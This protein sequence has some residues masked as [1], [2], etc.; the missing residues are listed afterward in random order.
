[1]SLT[2]RTLAACAV[3][4]TVLCA[5][6][7][8][9]AL[10]STTA[11]HPAASHS[12]VGTRGTSPRF[13]PASKPSGCPSGS[14]CIYHDTNGGDL[15]I[16]SP[17]NNPTLGSCTGIDRT[18]FNNGYTGKPDNVVAMNHLPNYKGAWTC[19]AAGNYWLDTSVYFFNGGP[20]TTGYGAT[21]EDAVSS[22]HW[23]QNNCGNNGP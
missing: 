7:A 21:V 22:F 11:S 2:R 16:A 5:A 13:V 1:M 17:V 4:L 12:R 6:P 19:I 23:Q 9:G 15:C 8:A 14:F 20:G 10:A 18:V 3:T